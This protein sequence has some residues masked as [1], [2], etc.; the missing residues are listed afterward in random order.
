[1]FYQDLPWMIRL[2]D[3]IIVIQLEIDAWAALATSIIK[4][5]IRPFNLM[6]ADSFITVFHDYLIKTSN[7]N[8]HLQLLVRPDFNQKFRKFFVCYKNY[9]KAGHS[10]IDIRGHMIDHLLHR[11]RGQEI[12]LSRFF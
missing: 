6:N 1:M 8:S 5:F 3:M 7:T 4:T 11:H 2:I 9:T 12:Y 10:L